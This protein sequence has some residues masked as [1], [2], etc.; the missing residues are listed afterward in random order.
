MPD[1]GSVAPVKK[2]TEGIFDQVAYAAKEQN[3]L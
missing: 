3:V 2:N 1:S